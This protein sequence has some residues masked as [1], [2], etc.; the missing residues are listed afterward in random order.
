MKD[1]AQL[2]RN[3][4][5]YPLLEEV[6]KHQKSFDYLATFVALK[7]NNPRT[8]NFQYDEDNEEHVKEFHAWLFRKAEV[9]KMLMNFVKPLFK[10]GSEVNVAAMKYLLKRYQ[11]MISDATK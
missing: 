11:N 10:T 6:L 1:A 4:V 2:W 3:W 5:K 9:K 8:V 7:R